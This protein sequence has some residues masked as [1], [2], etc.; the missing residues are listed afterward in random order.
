MNTAGRCLLRWRGCISRSLKMPRIKITAEI[1]LPAPGFPY[2]EVSNQGR[3]RSLPTGQSGKGHSTNIRILKP[4]AAE[5]ILT[6]GGL[7]GRVVQVARL[8]LEAFVS[9][10]PS[11]THKTR[12]L[13]DNREHNV[14]SNLTWGTQKDNV[15]DALRNKKFAPKFPEGVQYNWIGKKHSATTKAQM[16]Q[17]GKTRMAA[18]KA[19]GI[20][21]PRPEG[22]TF[23]GR[24]HSDETKELKRQ[25]KQAWNT[26]PEN[27]AAHSKRIQAWWDKRRGITP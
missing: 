24:H 22:L 5:V 19:A 13:D 12:H 9:P 11:L 4:R 1:W 6:K 2:Y 10:P 27:M 25:I 20:I 15:Q 18:R 16:S 23:K 26:I 17:S 21:Q 8:M 3:V 7:G 14:L